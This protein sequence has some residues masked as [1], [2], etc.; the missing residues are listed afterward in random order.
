MELEQTIGQLRSEIA[1]VQHATDSDNNSVVSD[2]SGESAGGTLPPNYR[3]TG[4]NTKV[5]GLFYPIVEGPHDAQY[6]LKTTVAF[7]VLAQSRTEM[8]NACGRREP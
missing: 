5:S 7:T 4:F 6:T 3:R 2:M 1:S 8:F